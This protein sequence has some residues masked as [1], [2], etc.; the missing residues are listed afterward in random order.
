MS[1]SV[2]LSCKKEIKHGQLFDIFVPID[3]DHVDDITSRLDQFFDVVMVSPAGCESGG[4]PCEG[5]NIKAIG[6][7]RENCDPE[8]AFAGIQGI[9]NMVWPEDG[10]KG[11]VLRGINDLEIH[12]RR[13]ESS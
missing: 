3:S 11:A 6:L 7:G 9:F 10:P 8:D 12:E 5:T 4:E 1:E 2:R 13:C